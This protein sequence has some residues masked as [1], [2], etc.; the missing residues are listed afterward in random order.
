MKL[1]KTNEYKRSL[2]ILIKKNNTNAIN[3]LLKIEVFLKTV[4]TFEDL[5]HNPIATLYKFEKLKNNLS[6]YSS[7]R[8]DKKTRLIVSKPKNNDSNNT[9]INSI[10]LNIISLDHYNDIDVKKLK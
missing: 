10:N 4:N 1:I 3:K 2:K 7:F 8:L 9:S 5:M 6:G